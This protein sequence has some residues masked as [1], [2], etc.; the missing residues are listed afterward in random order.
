MINDGFTLLFA[1]EA[2]IKIVGLGV[3]YF[4]N[5]SN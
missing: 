5:L 1:L 3:F 4:K 2:A